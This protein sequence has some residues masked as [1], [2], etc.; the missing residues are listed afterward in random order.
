MHSLCFTPADLLNLQRNA[1]DYFNK[2]YNPENGLVA[3]TTREDSPCS[4]AAVGFALSCYPIAVE[5]GFLAHTEALKRTLAVLRFFSNSEQSTRPQASGYKGFY[6]HFLSMKTGGRV[7]KCELST[8]DTT[9]LFYGA[10]MAAE[11]FNGDKP[12]EIEVRELTEILLTRAD[13]R[14]ATNDRTRVALAWKPELLKR[15]N[16]FLKA[17]WSGYNEAILLQI[18]ALGS[19]EYS[20]PKS[21]YEDWC[22]TYDW[23]T[24]YG[25]ETLY[26]G[27]LFIHQFPHL[28]IDFKSIRDAAMHDKNCD[29]FENSR[30]ATFIQQEYSRRNPRGFIGYNEN[31]WGI[32]AGDGPGE[33][34]RHLN[35]RQQKYFAYR[36]RGVPFGPDDGTLA[37]WAVIASLPFAPEIVLPALHHIEKTYPEMTNKFGFHCS[38][39]PSFQTKGS[40]WIASEYFGLD[41]G[42]IILAIEN[43]LSGLP[44]QLMRKNPIIQKGLQRAGFTGGWLIETKM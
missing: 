15:S 27:P 5:R 1:F 43:H 35:N 4:I 31:C 44:W 36:A 32:T 39:N 6:Y 8:I 40:F 2:V 37:P 17:H 38:F 26:A 9:L 19:T 16:G 23:K 34:T 7:W 10:L 28:W 3:D 20:L 22:S 41:Q 29:Y 30:R 21:S 12:E 14:W 18:L 25:I 24:I 33:K 13:W 42:P 11:Y